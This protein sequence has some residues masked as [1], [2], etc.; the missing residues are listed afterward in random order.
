MEITHY[1][2]LGLLG[3][4]VLAGAACAEMPVSE[5]LRDARDTVAMAHDTP[6]AELEPDQLRVAERTLAH[7]NAAENGSQIEI[8]LAYVADRQARM[9]IANANRARALE[10]AET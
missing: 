9:A 3:G 7:A 10:N 5:Q 8:D 6:A 4:F 1:R 2:S